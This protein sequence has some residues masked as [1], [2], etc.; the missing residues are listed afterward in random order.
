MKCLSFNC[1]G[2][3]SSPKKLALRRL[4]DSESLDII[5]L[6]ETLGEADL[7]S[8]TLGS[9]KLGW[10]FQSLDV[11]GRSGGLALGYNPRT[12]NLRTSCGGDKFIGMDIFSSELG[13]D[14]HT[15]NVYGP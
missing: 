2:L 13:V 12:I 8:H 7:I 10:I 11:I 9:L 4:F 14:L 15:V 3:A 5:F 1:R 6:Q